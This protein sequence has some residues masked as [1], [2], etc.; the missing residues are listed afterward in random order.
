MILSD[1]LLQKRIIPK[2]DIERSKELWK[3]K[4]WKDVGNKIL[5]DPFKQ[6]EL[7][8]NCYNLHVGNQYVSLRD[9]DKIKDV[10]NSIKIEPGETVLILT[11]EYVALPK[12]VFSFVIPKARLIFEGIIIN[13]TKIDPTWYGKLLIATTNITKN[14][15]KLGKDEVFCSIYLAESHEVKNQLNKH[16]T[17][18]LGREEIKSEDITHPHIKFEPFIYPE[19]VT[20]EDLDRIVEVYGKPWDIIKGMFMLSKDDIIKYM[21]KEIQP[22]LIEEAKK[23][24]YKDAYNKMI[25]LFYVIVG[26]FGALI[27]TLLG[28]IIKIVFFP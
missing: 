8:L 1:E 28:S 3:N 10:E 9:S 20:K 12:N 27:L 21:E 11:R 6:E 14:P 17:P 25:K 5:I 19:R 2:E 24:A 15:I 4:Q 13:A 18:S 22:H 23:E 7:D 16:R 26:L